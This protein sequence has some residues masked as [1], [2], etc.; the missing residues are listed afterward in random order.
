MLLS[1][2]SLTAATVELIVRQPFFLDLV[3]YDNVMAETI[4]IVVPCSLAGLTIAFFATVRGQ[5]KLVVIASVVLAL[6]NL[7]AICYG[8][9]FFATLLGD[10]LAAQAWWL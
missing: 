6:A 7:S 3:P 9:Y 10:G 4:N 8:H 5:M 1:H 2:V